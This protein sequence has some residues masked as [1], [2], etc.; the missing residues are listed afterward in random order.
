MSTKAL[1]KATS[2][3][4]VCLYEVLGVDRDADAE[5]LKKAY[6]K[7]AL[8]VLTKSNMISFNLALTN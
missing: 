5:A 3:M 6:R 2:N 8:K 7:M 1:S 4:V